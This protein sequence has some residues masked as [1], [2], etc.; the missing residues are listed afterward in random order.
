MEGVVD[1][2]FHNANAVEMSHWSVRPRPRYPV[3][4][5]IVAISSLKACGLT[6]AHVAEDFKLC[7][8]VPL[9]LRLS[10]AWMNVVG[11]DLDQDNHC[12]LHFFMSP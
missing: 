8:L 11:F 7:Q 1:P 3:R 6:G 12:K 5:S 2:E 4:A 10:P 9:K